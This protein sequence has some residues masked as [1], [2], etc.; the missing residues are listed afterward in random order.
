MGWTNSHLHLFRIGLLEYGAPGDDEEVGF[1]AA[2]ENSALL[3]CLGLRKGSKVSYDDDFGDSWAHEILVEKIEPATEVHS[4]TC[5][6]SG[7]RACP[8]EDCGGVP[9]YYRALNVLKKARTEDDREFKEWLGDYDPE[10]F[11]LR[12][13]NKS[14]GN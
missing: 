12:S 7:A 3:S 6:L 14:L 1:S 5:C 13:I 11:D 9:G 2:D 8:P 4:R 10:Q